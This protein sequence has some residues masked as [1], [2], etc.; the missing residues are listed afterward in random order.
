VIVFIRTLPL[1][2]ALAALLAFPSFIGS[3][4]DGGTKLIDAVSR[5]QAVM[6]GD[7]EALEGFKA[8]SL[9]PTDWAAPRYE[10]EWTPVIA[11]ASGLRQ[12]DPLLAEILKATQL[13]ID[14][15]LARQGGR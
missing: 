8:P 13:P 3:T 2:L 7:T 14:A 4:K 1:T 15:H 10:A 11:S 6:E 9:K 12:G 5:L